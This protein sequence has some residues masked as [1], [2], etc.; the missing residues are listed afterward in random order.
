MKDDK[1]LFADTKTASRPASS[2]ARPLSEGKNV[3][4]ELCGQVETVL[5]RNE[6]NGYV[7]CIVVIE[8]GTLV[9]TVGIMPDIEDGDKLTATGKW[10]NNARYGK[11]FRV[12][13]YTVE[14]PT[15]NGDIERYL[16]SGA[17]K[18]IGVKTARKIVAEFGDDTVDVIENHP[19]WLAQIPGITHKRAQE[20]SEEFKSKSDLRAT[21]TFFREYFGPALTMKIY[22]EFGNRSIQVARDNPYRL[23]EDVD[24]I[25]FEKADSMAQKL[26]LPRESEERLAAGISYVLSSDAA[27]NGHTCLPEEI[28]V[29]EGARILGVGAEAIRET[30]K[31]MISRH[32]LVAEKTDGDRL[33]YNKES[34]DD[35]KFVADKLALLRRGSIQ[36]SF[37]DIEAFI[38]KE[39]ASNGIKY[40]DEQKKAIFEAL[41]GGVLLLTGGPGTGK[42]TVVTA[43]IAIFESMELKVAL[44]APTGRAAKRMTEATGREAKTVHRLLEVDFGGDDGEIRERERSARIK[45]R[46]CADYLLD[47]H[48]IIVDEASMLDL[49]LTASLLRAVKPGARLIFI[50][51][52][53][54]LPSVGAGNVLHDMLASESLPTVRL[55]RIFRQAE[56][57]LIVTN[58]HAINRGEMPVLDVKDRDFFFMPRQYDDD[59]ANTVGELCATRLP[60]AYGVDEVIQVISPT[61]RGVV[62]TEALNARLQLLINPPAREKKEYHHRERL[63]RVGDKVM[64]IRNNYELEWIRGSKSGLGI[65]NGDIGRITDINTI[66]KYIEIDFDGREVIYEFSILDDL[67]LAYAIT[68]HKSQGS[69]YSTVVISLGGVNPALCTRNLLYTAVTRA[70]NRVI[71]VGRVDTIAAM[72]AN[73]KPTVRHTGLERRIRERIGKGV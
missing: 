2:G 42:T 38:R 27:Q 43:L 5:Y 72:V 28:L 49:S 57:S 67:D 20:I 40:A 7:V 22:K 71:I 11:Q 34:Y 13:E 12:L 54:Q 69:E 9:N 60:R 70:K 46:R 3:D 25:G 47:E 19:D 65:F 41:N 52:S 14:L 37:S 58:A 45:F 31:S 32:R 62:G 16:A 68:V 73:L 61:K 23:C 55:D 1:K 48:V 21:V 53:D 15:E 66:E 59:V 24:G 36:L 44:A 33:I 63:F 56:M 6:D 35:E 18:G 17:I 26:G 51:D 8:D 4:R 64:Q 39:E 30:I 10:E 29:N 50:G